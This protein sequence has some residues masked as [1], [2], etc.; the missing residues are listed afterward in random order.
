MFTSR[1][2]CKSP[3]CSALIAAGQG[4]Y[5]LA[6]GRQRTDDR[7]QR[8]RHRGSA[9]NRG[10]DHTWQRER[11]AFLA[12]YPLCPGV[13]LPTADWTM[14]LAIAFHHLREQAREAGKLLIFS[15]EAAEPRQEDSISAPSVT[16]CKTFLEHHPIY[17]WRPYDVARPATVVDHIIPHKGDPLLMWAEWNWQPLAKRAHDRK[18]A[19]EKALSL[20]NPCPSVPSVAKKSTQPS[21]AAASAPPA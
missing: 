20:S 3:G 15:P 4:S 19:T 9:A 7:A 17:T 13:L 5:C 8:D 11:A 16:S 14:E 10:Y 6:H 12:K 21:T 2:P 18:T 1:H